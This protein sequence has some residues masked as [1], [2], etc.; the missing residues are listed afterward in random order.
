MS[1][2][3]NDEYGPDG[4]LVNGYDYDRQAWVIDRRYVDCGHADAMDCECYGRRHAGA[5]VGDYERAR[6]L[7]DLIDTTQHVAAYFVTAGRKVAS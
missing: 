5:A 3:S 7:D 4:L 6:R 1:R 2:V